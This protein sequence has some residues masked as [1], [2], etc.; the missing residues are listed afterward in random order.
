MCEAV[1][2]RPDQVLL[3]ESG[4]LPIS[5]CATNSNRAATMLKNKFD[6]AP[7]SYA[8]FV[9]IQDRS[10]RGPACAPVEQSVA[11]IIDWLLHEASRIENVLY[12]FEEFL[13]RCR[14][15]GIPVDRSSLHIGTLHPRIIGFS[16][17]WNSS[18]E[19]C[20]EVIAEAGA[21]TAPSFTRNPLARV[22]ETGQTL[23]VDL[24]T[25]EGRAA[26]PLMQELADEGYTEYAILPLTTAG[27]RH[28]A[29]TFATRHPDGFPETVAED[30]RMLM[31]ILALHVERHILQRIAQNVVDTY[32]GPSAGARVLSGEIRRGDGEAIDAVVWMSDLRGFTTLS[33]RLEGP[34]VSA[35]LNTY[36][37]IVSDAVLDH[38]GDILKFI[39]DGILAVFPTASTNGAGAGER[40][41]AAARSAIAR[42]E[43]VNANPTPELAEIA[44]WAPLKMGIGLHEGEVFFGNVGGE[45][46]LDFTVIGRAVNETSRVEALCKELKRPLLFTEPVYRSLTPSQRSEIELMGSYKLRGVEKDM[47]IYTVGSGKE[48]AAA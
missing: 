34:Q 22:M 42:L 27:D 19:F 5:I 21:M 46:R 47:P 9:Y 24:R 7:R 8:P 48:S 4:E 40:A 18:D 25:A 30:T 29:I 31:D 36:F 35:V 32:L 26:F 15:A 14:A 11:K 1:G 23:Q 43:D 28:N 39:G 44:G 45:S 2:R 16:W 12:M 3:V 6:P 41:L 33:D 37:E 20:D 10:R 13:W 38:G 17:V